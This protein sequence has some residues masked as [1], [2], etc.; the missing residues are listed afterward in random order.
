V[1]T[2]KKDP[3][4]P[5]IDNGKHVCLNT[6][7]VGI[8]LKERKPN[9]LGSCGSFEGTNKVNVESL[10]YVGSSGLVHLVSTCRKVVN[11]CTP[12]AMQ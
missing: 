11:M 1:H 2:L 3:N 12:A 9:S 10:E 5:N 4:P 8:P 7:D 6:F